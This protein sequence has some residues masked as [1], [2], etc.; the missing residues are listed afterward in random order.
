MKLRKIR[1]YMLKL[2][3]LLWQ[4]LDTLDQKLGPGAGDH[5]LS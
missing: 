5:R 3:R 4:M 2:Q 1:Y